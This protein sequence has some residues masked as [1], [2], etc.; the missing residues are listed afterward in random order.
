MNKT[1][2]YK[3]HSAQIP[4]APPVGSVVIDKDGMAWQRTSM[5]DPYPD[6][7]SAQLDRSFDGKNI[8][9][10]SQLLL[11]NP[12]GLTEVYRAKESP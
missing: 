11:A 9:Y 10:W 7:C 12:E 4:A 1:P 8:N 5:Q 2:L 3:I 6:W